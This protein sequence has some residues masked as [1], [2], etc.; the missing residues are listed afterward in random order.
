MAE[1]HSN[2]ASEFDVLSMLH[3][4][5]AVAALTHGNTNAVDIIVANEA[6]TTTTIDAKGL[7]E[8]Y[9]GCLDRLRERYS[10]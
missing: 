3:R 1:Y 9:D 4:L 6:A 2:L 10:I 8:R 7:E 5:G